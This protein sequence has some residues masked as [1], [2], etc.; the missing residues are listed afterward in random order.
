MPIPLQHAER[1]STRA[2]CLGAIAA[3][4]LCSAAIADES[5]HMHSGG[6]AFSPILGVGWNFLAADRAAPVARLPGVLEGG[7][8]RGDERGGELD[9]IEAGIHWR[10]HEMLSGELRLARH[11]E[12]DGSID[13][14][15]AWLQYRAELG[16]G[17]LD[18]RVGRMQVPV[19]RLN[20]SHRHDWLFGVEPRIYR[21][22]IGDGWIDD[23][24]TLDMRAARGWRAGVGVFRGKPFPGANVAGAGALTLNAGLSSGPWVV[25]L[26]LAVVDAP[27]RALDTSG[28]SSASHSHSQLRC[29][30]LANDRVCFDG[31]ATLAALSASWRQPRGP[32][33]VDGE[34]WIKRDRGELASLNGAPDYRGRVSGGWLQL[35]WQPAGAWQAALRYEHLVVGHDVD[36]VGA[37][38]VARQAGIADSDRRLSRIG[39]A[40]CWRPVR[41]QRTTLELY[42]DRTLADSADVVLLRLQFD[43][44]ALGA[45]SI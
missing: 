41:W 17:R 20:R 24:A 3:A 16:Y 15:A 13:V 43:L 40:L 12:G 27:G 4:T 18:T 9:Y 14:E 39:L 33:R 8:A 2:R 10:H 35:G 22:A 25:E 38:L 44:A 31:H 21:A 37:S 30:R 7:S 26:D 19:G 1:P 11:G 36:G 23:G 6:A 29:E 5:H 28:M 42:R 34:F 45:R 32:L